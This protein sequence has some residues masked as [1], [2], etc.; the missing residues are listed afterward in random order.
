M[1]RR[2]PPRGRRRLRTAPGRGATA[3]TS[4]RSSAQ[5]PEQPC[6]SKAPAAFEGCRRDAE[7]RRGFLDAEAGKVAELDDP[8]LLGID[9]LEPL[10]RLVESRQHRVLGAGADQRL[11]QRDAVEPGPTL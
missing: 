10:E 6:A 5:L 8:G 3:P 4:R 7:R 1:K 11:A 9:F 2:R